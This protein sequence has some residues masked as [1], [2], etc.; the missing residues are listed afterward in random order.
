[1][2]VS[3]RFGVG[4]VNGAGQDPGWVGLGNGIGPGAVEPQPISDRTKNRR[5]ATTAE[6]I[7]REDLAQDA[8]FSPFALQ[9]KM[10]GRDACTAGLARTS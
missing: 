9:G 5:D 7:Q 10:P 3:I 1:M 6:K 2:Q 8:R 4:F